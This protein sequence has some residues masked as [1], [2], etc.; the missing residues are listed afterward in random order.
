MEGLYLPSAIHTY[1]SCMILVPRPC[2][3]MQSTNFFLHVSHSWVT[4]PIPGGLLPVSWQSLI[5][6]CLMNRVG[7][8]TTRGDQV[9]SWHLVQGD[10]N[11]IVDSHRGPIILLW[12]V[13]GNWLSYM[14]WESPWGLIILLCTVQG[15]IVQG[16][17]TL[18]PCRRNGLATFASSHCY[19]HCLKVGSTN[20]MSEHCHM[21]I[22]KLNCIVHWNVTVMPI[23]FQ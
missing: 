2:T 21:T 11:S 6:N 19:F 14:Y 15:S 20:Q 18:R 7:P 16:S 10:W 22:V 12:T 13:Q 3:D 8:S 1:H 9:R 5:M 23:P 4:L 17:L